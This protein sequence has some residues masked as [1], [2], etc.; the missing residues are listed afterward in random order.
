LKAAA[1]WRF[2]SVPE[3]FGARSAT[4]TFIFRK[5]SYVPKENERDFKPPYQMSVT[6]EPT[7]DTFADGALSEGLSDTF[8]E[9]VLGDPEKFLLRLKSEPLGTR[10]K[11]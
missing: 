9:Q 5:T 3:D 6:W 4:L 2:N 1:G 10:R 8:A 11:V 7:F